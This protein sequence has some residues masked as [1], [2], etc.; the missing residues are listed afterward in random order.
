MIHTAPTASAFAC[1]RTP[2]QEEAREY[3]A[4]N[5]RLNYDKAKEV[6]KAALYSGLLSYQQPPRHGNAGPR[7]DPTPSKGS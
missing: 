6:V 2:L 4:P 1:K 5:G 7:L 3:F